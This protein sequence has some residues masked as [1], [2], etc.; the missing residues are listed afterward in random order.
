[1]KCLRLYVQTFNAFHILQSIYKS[2]PVSKGWHQR[3]AL[4][5]ADTKKYQNYTGK[6][7]TH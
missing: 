2:M 7:K 6:M 1:M 3:Y 4:G 5:I